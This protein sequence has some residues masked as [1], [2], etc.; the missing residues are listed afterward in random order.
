[1]WPS[2]PPTC[3][4]EFIRVAFEGASLTGTAVEALKGR[5]F[6]YLRERFTGTRMI[7]GG[8]DLDSQHCRRQR[9]D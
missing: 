3:N 2:S 6:E 1:M 5:L 8:F 4:P 9:P 7:C